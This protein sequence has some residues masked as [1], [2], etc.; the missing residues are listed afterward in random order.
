MRLT[1]I[2]NIE[3]KTISSVKENCVYSAYDRERQYGNL[4]ADGIVG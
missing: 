3:S 4:Y 1:F 2:Y